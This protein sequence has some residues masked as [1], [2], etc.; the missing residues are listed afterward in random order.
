MSI[1]QQISPTT[2]PVG[3]TIEINT[4]GWY[5]WGNSQ[6]IFTNYGK[7]II[8]KKGY[9]TNQADLTN[10]AYLNN[11]EGGLIENSG[12]FENTRFWA[13]CAELVNDGEFSNEK[14]GS[15]INDG[16]LHNNSKA[17]L[18]NDGKIV[19]N[20]GFANSK[21][22]TGVLYNKGTFNNNSGAVFLNYGNCLN[23]KNA[24]IN[25]AGSFDAYIGGGSFGNWGHF[26]NKKGAV[27]HSSPAPSLKKDN[28]ND[29]DGA[30]FN[31]GLISNAGIVTNDGLINARGGFTNQIGALI[32]GSGVIKGDLIN[33]GTINS[34]SSSGGH[35]IDGNLQHT[36]SSLN[37]FELGGDDDASRDRKNTQYDFLDIKGDL[38]IDGGTLDIQLINNFKIE[39]GQEFK[40][41]SVG[42]DLVGQYAGF[43][44]GSS[45]GLFDSIHSRA[46]NLFITYQGGDGNDICLYTKDQTNADM[47]FSFN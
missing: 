8:D 19:N 27:L 17:V 47:I 34:G 6:N 16:H 45:V 4:T 42:N 43:D 22:S 24:V 23:Y 11:K 18:N 33:H 31:V 41:V 1:E 14:G 30:T 37:T 40:I 26:N 39:Y 35:L 10:W 3:H 36:N 25:N 15:L 38:L 7:I 13:S 46:I 32:Q 28:L 44:E 21:N 2:L 20:T 9:L 29:H 5:N 12:T